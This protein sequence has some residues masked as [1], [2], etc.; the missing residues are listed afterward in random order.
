MRTESSL[1]IL[2]PTKNRPNRLEWCLNHYTKHKFAGQIIVCDASDDDQSKNICDKQQSLQLTYFPCQTYM[3]GGDAF[4]FANEL[5]MTPYVVS[6]GDDDVLLMQWIK[7]A[8]EFLNS[9]SGDVVAVG[10][11]RVTRVKLEDGL[12]IIH[13]NSINNLD[14]D[15]WIRLGTYLRLKVTLDNSVHRTKTWKKMYKYAPN[16]PNRA[17]G[18]EVLPCCISAINGK[19][20]FL[21]EPSIFRLDSGDSLTPPSNDNFMNQ[22]M[23]QPFL[24]SY[25]VMRHAIITEFRKLGLEDRSVVDFCDRELYLSFLLLLINKF[26]EKWPTQKVVIDIYCKSLDTYPFPWR[27]DELADQQDTQQSTLDYASVFEELL[28]P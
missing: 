19:H 12:G 11:I 25:Q 7:T 10:G 24:I 14:D 27:R 9:C 8:I 21:E 2:I 20:A 6:H 28:C 4:T 22:M 3:H 26:V 13:T 15:P 5:V 16:M 23:S 18:C 1:T 17:L